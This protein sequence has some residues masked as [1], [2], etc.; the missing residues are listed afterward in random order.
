[1]HDRSWRLSWRMLR[2]FLWAVA[3]AAICR[4]AVAGDKPFGP[5]DVWTLPQ[6]AW[7]GCLQGRTAPT[8]CL[9]RLMRQTKASPQAME[10]FR[11]LDG[12]GFMSAFRPMG[13]VDLATMTFPFRA[14]TNEAAFLI[15][16]HPD[17]VSTELS[18]TAVDIT[19]DPAYV[20]LRQTYPDL[21]LWPTSAIFR[22]MDSLPGGGQGFVFAYPVLNGCHA[23]ALAGYAL[24]SLD[25][26]PQGT[27]LGPRFLQLET[28]R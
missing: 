11:R 22:R 21:T 15:N 14:N 28:D 3:M 6:A 24:I 27:F 26:S 16:G 18:E 2:I 20:H 17:L 5:A 13:R 23:C 8:D 7:N 10:I 4:P 19:A 1:M 25:F 9:G 12:D